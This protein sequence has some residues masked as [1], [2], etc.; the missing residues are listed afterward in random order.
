MVIIN[1]AYTL[2]TVINCVHAYAC[3]QPVECSCIFT[4]FEDI[5]SFVSAFTALLFSENETAKCLLS[6]KFHGMA[7]CQHSVSRPYTHRAIVKGHNEYLTYVTICMHT[8]QDW[9]MQECH[10]S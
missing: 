5:G 8:L 6:N 9:R 3:E 10:C 4:M 7:T 2:W 1:V